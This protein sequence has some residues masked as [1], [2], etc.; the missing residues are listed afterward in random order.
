MT[1]TDKQIY[2]NLKKNVNSHIGLTY[3]LIQIIYLLILLESAFAYKFTYSFEQTE[4]SAILFFKENEV[5]DTEKSSNYEVNIIFDV[6]IMLINK[7]SHVFTYEKENFISLSILDDILSSNNTGNETKCGIIECNF[8]LSYFLKLTKNIA[9]L[10]VK[11]NDDKIKCMLS[12]LKCFKAVENKMFKEFLNALIF[13]EFVFIN[14]NDARQSFLNQEELFNLSI[15]SDYCIIKVIISSFF[16][17]FMIE[18]VFYGGNLILLEEPGVNFDVSFFDIHVPY[19][20]LLINNTKIFF[21]LEN[22]LQNIRCRNIFRFVLN[23]IDIRSV[24]INYLQESRILNSSI[25]FHILRFDMLKSIIISNFNT[26]SIYFVDKLF[27]VLDQNIDYLSLKNTVVNKN[28]LDDLFVRLKLKG[29]VLFG[30]CLFE[31]PDPVENYLYFNKTL[32]YLNL[33]VLNACFSWLLNVFETKNLRKLILTFLTSNAQKN[34]MKEFCKVNTNTNI[35]HIEICFFDELFYSFCDSLSYFKSLQTLIISR[36]KTDGNTESCL[37]KA[38]KSMKNLEHIEILHYGVSEKFYNFLLQKRGIKNIVLKNFIYSP[39]TLK[40]D[41]LNNN[42]SISEFFLNNVK[43]TEDSLI[44]ICKCGTLTKLK[45]N[46][47]NLEPSLVSSQYSLLLKNIVSL[48]L[49][50]S[51]LA[52]IKNMNILTQLNCLETLYI[53]KC[54]F[55]CGYLAKLSSSCNLKLK[56]LSYISGILDA[57]DLDRIK[58]MEVLRELNLSRSKF[59]KCGFYSF[60]HSTKFLG[61]LKD[62]NLNFVKIDLED[63]KLIR[64][65]RELERLTLTFSNVNMY[66]ENGFVVSHNLYRIASKNIND[67]SNYYKLRCYLREEVAG[68]YFYD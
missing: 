37:I 54:G 34:F 67:M 3:I 10:P 35:L 44:E 11:L 41:S 33:K 58:K 61:F 52:I 39:N 21:I 57:N 40:F 31:G 25:L 29:L 24:I 23:S 38:I 26:S 50:D 66:T 51:N 49:E 16:K 1:Y 27:K 55:S 32:E 53:S 22:I 59:K 8:E 45:L 65:F 13:T 43:I 47:C 4:D 48:Y 17:A 46:V 63:L 14:R 20:N 36:F 56:S 60:G 15:K 9:E 7:K 6:D 68:I 64:E 19:R 28:V 30:N 12:V 2:T 18:H 42:V 62:L 5:F